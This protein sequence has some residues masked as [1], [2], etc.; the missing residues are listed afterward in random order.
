MIK[1][2]FALLALISILFTACASSPKDAETQAAAQESASAKQE[3]AA[4]TGALSATEVS[5]GELAAKLQELEKLSVYFDFDEY[6]VKAEY[7]DIV[8]QYA[9]FMKD[10]ENIVITLE[11]NADERGS[12]EYN[13]SLG[14]KRASAVRKALGLLG[15]P[16]NRIK[17]VSFGEE[18]PRLTCHEERCW[19]ENRRVDFIGKLE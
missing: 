9:E 18:R 4:T 16:G 12:G 19:K 11:G 10:H 15:V 3:G 6:V 5:S 17:A 14:D 2:K 8:M 1:A 13:L 7:R